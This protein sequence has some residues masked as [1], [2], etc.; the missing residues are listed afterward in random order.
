M[1]VGDAIVWWRATALYPYN[2]TIK[3]AGI[4]LVMSTLGQCDVAIALYRVRTIFHNS[5]GAGLVNLQEIV[6]GRVSPGVFQPEGNFEVY[7]LGLS[8]QWDTSTGAQIFENS[9]PG[10]AAAILSF[11]TN[12]IATCLVVYKAWYVLGIIIPCYMYQFL[13]SDA[14]VGDKGN[15]RKMFP[16]T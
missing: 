10:L 4:M 12:A 2:K 14:L 3:F 7:N 11:S 15:T 9:K 1:A 13:K 5:T 6:S 8:G 16:V